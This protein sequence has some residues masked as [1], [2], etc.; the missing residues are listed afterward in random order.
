MKVKDH[1]Y[2]FDSHPRNE[3]GERLNKNQHKGL[4]CALRF[5]SIESMSHSLMKNFVIENSSE[6]NL[7]KIEAS[8][9]TEEEKPLDLKNYTKFMNYKFAGIQIAENDLHEDSNEF[10]INSPEKTYSNLV[11]CLTMNELYPAIHWNSKDI[12]EILRLG[13]NLMLRTPTNEDYR[14]WIEM[15]CKIGCNRFKVTSEMEKFVFY[16]DDRHENKEMCEK[17]S[18]LNS[19]NVNESASLDGIESVDDDDHEKFIEASSKEL[20]I[21]TTIE[22]KINSL[23]GIDT[24]RIIIESNIFSVALWKQGN[25]FFVFDPK[26][27]L[28]DGT[29]SDA[30][31]QLIDNLTRKARLKSKLRV[32]SQFQ[33]NTS[34]DS[35]LEISQEEL[36][37]YGVP[38][39]YLS[40]MNLPAKEKSDE[41]SDQKTL[42]ASVIVF[43]NKQILLKHLYRNIPE[44]HKYSEFIWHFI[45]INNEINFNSIENSSTWHHFTPIKA[46]N[47]ILRGN[48]SLKDDERCRDSSNCVIALCFSALIDPSKWNS[49]LIDATMKYGARLYTSSVQKN[50]KLRS[51]TLKGLEISEIIDEFVIAKTKFRI[52]FT[53]F[54]LETTKIERNTHENGIEI[55]ENSNPLPCLANLDKYLSQFFNLNEFGVLK[56]KKYAV[57]VFKDNENAFYMFDPHSTGPNGVRSEFGV[58]SLSRFLSIKNLCDVFLASIDQIDQG[59]NIFELFNV[60]IEHSPLNQSKLE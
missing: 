2:V 56:S 45:T 28:A 55:Q 53:R 20:S 8:I 3:K 51:V 37:R 6:F 48:K 9:D 29:F 59:P 13:Y 57:S 35:K 11:T 58:A 38:K 1:F 30:R 14:A 47:W 27:T 18:K 17:I 25:L 31:I 54:D 15:N 22:D 5:T 52:Q 23:S 32:M 16:V 19:F 7:I 41:I 21:T 10:P 34:E 40:L 4:A 12:S 26:P 60:E 39:V 43:S 36:R 46:N 24:A 49:S 42:G 33:V 44:R 50:R